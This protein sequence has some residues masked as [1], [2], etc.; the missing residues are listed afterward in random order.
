MPRRKDTVITIST[1]TMR[2]RGLDISLDRLARAGDTLYIGFTY[3]D[4]PRFAFIEQ[5]LLPER[6][7][8]VNRFTLYPGVRPTLG[9][10]YVDLDAV[11]TSGDTW[12]VH[13]HFLD[14]IVHE[15]HGYELLDA[16]EL[17]EGIESD[18]IA[19][20]EVL[21]AL[22]ALDALCRELRRLDFSGHALLDVHAT[23]LPK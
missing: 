15:G 12:L 4:H 10:W 6:G 1:R 8:I 11:T 13:D 19:T 17:A 14:L 3:P 20:H 9:D 2:I 21:G 5:W 7:W 18:E 22:R 23:G 16:D